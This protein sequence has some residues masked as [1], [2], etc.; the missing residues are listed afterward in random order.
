M[1]NLPFQSLNL[2]DRTKKGKSM[3]LSVLSFWKRDFAV[4][5]SENIEV[6][7]LFSVSTSLFPNGFFHGSFEQFCLKILKEIFSQQ[8]FF[9]R[10][11][12]FSEELCVYRPFHLRALIPALEGY[13]VG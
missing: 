1:V 13:K 6:G 2:E 5:Y 12:V 11:S 10:V 8:R 9:R 4:V 7:S 3:V